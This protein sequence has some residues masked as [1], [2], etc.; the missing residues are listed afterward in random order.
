[1]AF[2]ADEL[3]T[4]N[5]PIIPS[6]QM[7]AIE[8]IIAYSEDVNDFTKRIIIWVL[9]KTNNLTR[10]VVVSI[11]D[12]TQGFG[13]H[14]M[15]SCNGTTHIDLIFQAMG[16][17]M[18]LMCHHGVLVRKGV[19]DTA[20]SGMTVWFSWVWYNLYPEVI[21]H[22]NYKEIEAIDLNMIRNSSTH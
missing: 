16:T 17:E 12:L 2:F 8:K 7:K 18:S 21:L 1:M 13:V 14:N 3:V 10:N 20:R 9:R 11:E 5:P 6:S 22:P 19:L 15:T 4:Y